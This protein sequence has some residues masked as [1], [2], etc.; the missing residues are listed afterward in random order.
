MPYGRAPRGARAGRARSGRA[1]ARGP[2]P[3]PQSTVGS[4]VRAGARTQPH[5][6]RRRRLLE[7]RAAG[8]FVPFA[9]C[10]SRGFFPASTAIVMRDTQVGRP[11]SSN[12]SI[13]Q[14]CVVRPRWIGL[15][16]PV[17]QPLLAERR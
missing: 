1:A 5:E 8:E 2:A 6:R 14:T 12:R 7:E 17:T 15:A 9:L 3:V 4:D 11:A 10:L 16:T 13:A